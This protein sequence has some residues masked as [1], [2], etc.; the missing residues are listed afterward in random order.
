[1]KKTEFKNGIEKIHTD[2]TTINYKVV[3]TIGTNS[4]LGG[5]DC[6][7]QIKDLWHLY[8]GQ[9]V[10]SKENT[11][12][13]RKFGFS[14]EIKTNNGELGTNYN[15]ICKH[16]KTDFFV[17]CYDYNPS[18]S[19]ENQEALYITRS[20]LFYDFIFNVTTSRNAPLY[21]F[22]KIRN[23]YKIDIYKRGYP[24][25]ELLFNFFKHYCMSFIEFN[26][27]IE[28]D[29]NGKPTENEKKY[30]LKNW[31]TLF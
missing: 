30:I 9:N 1:M 15:G 18:V 2:A 25:E 23:N 16:R 11:D 4:G 19:I 17:Y 3:A 14:F 26:S 27:M 5:M 31:L 13:I 28:N 21:R 8:N 24:K 7:A 20:D 6:E 12:D 10:V 29:F 22:D